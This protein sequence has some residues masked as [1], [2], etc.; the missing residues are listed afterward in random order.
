MTDD[1]IQRRLLALED[2]LAI[3]ELE[4][5]YCRW[6]DARDGDAWA[7]LFTEGGIYRGVEVTADSP[8]DAGVYCEGRAALR[9]FCNKAPFTGIHFMH[10]PELTIEGDVARGRVH[11]EHV[12]SFE[13]EGGALHRAIGYGDTR[14]ERVDGQWLFAEKVTTTWERDGVLFNPYLAEAP[15]G[16]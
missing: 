8:R 13:R 14:Y 3:I 9:S 7:A 2:R 4:S 1:D 16:T 6:F 15:P 11:F 10:L 5:A 12:G